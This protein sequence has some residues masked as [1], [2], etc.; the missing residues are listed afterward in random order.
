VNDAATVGPKFDYPKAVEAILIFV[1]PGVFTA[2]L[3]SLIWPWNPF[4]IFFLTKL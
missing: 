3:L 1:K 4:T 2:V